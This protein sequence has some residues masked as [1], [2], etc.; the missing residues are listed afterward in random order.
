V[1]PGFPAAARNSVLGTANRREDS[2]GKPLPDGSD[3]VKA[4]FGEE[5]GFVFMVDDI[6]FRLSLPASA[7]TL[8]NDV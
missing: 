6:S 3:R 1:T 2:Q 4:Q 7:A 5:H 8:R